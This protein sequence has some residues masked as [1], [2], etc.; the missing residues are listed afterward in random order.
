MSQ[1]AEMEFETRVQVCDSP[2][3]RVVLGARGW[4][5][6]MSALLGFIAGL[7]IGLRGRRHW[8]RRMRRG[9][10]ERW[11]WHKP[12]VAPIRLPSENPDVETEL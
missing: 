8:L 11:G 1:R 9:D 12:T 5:L 7:A 6:F 10:L 3:A 2:G 4:P